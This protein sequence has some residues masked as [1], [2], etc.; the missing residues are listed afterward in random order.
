M[1]NIIFGIVATLGLILGVLSY[2]S[3]DD[4]NQNNALNAPQTG[5]PDCS[6]LGNTILPSPYQIW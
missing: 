2:I 3:D 5:C 6:A 1:F 4:G